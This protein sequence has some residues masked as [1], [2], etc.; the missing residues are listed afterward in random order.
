MK[1]K[2]PQ[3]IYWIKNNYLYVTNPDVEVISISAFFEEDVPVK[4]LKC[5]STITCNN[6][7]DD[8]FKF[9]GY[10]EK[11]LKDMVHDQIMKTYFRHLQDPTP[12]GK[13]EAR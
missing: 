9:P 7:L 6:P 3:Y 5:S 13:D 8:E 1:L 11:T 12:N 4:L 2:T 10:L